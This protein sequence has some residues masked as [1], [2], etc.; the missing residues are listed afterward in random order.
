MIMC[1]IVSWKLSILAITSIFP[2]IQITRIYSKS[3][4]H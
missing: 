4:P 2:I 1:F 3:A